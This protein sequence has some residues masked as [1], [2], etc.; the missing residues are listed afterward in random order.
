LVQETIVEARRDFHQSKSETGPQLEAWLKAMLLNNLADARKRYRQTAKRD[1]R[2]ERSIHVSR[3]QE[4]LE[5]V[6]QQEFVKKARDDHRQAIRDRLARALKRLPREK[7]AIILWVHMK[8]R[9][10]HE[11]AEL[12]QK[13]YDATRAFWK[14]ALLQLKK[15]LEKD[16]DDSDAAS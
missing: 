4:L 11:I 3:I 13:S 1:L 7:R 6:V 10:L 5:R 2:R 15:E 12:V 8:G 9:S 16:K 14:R